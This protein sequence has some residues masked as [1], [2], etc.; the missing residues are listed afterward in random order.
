MKNKFLKLFCLCF[1]GYLSGCTP[2]QKYTWNQFDESVYEYYKSPNER[3]NY[4]EALQQIIKLSED[5]GKIPP[6]IYAEYGYVN[7]ETGNYKEAVKY[8]QKEHDTWPESR[9]FMNKMI[10]NAKNLD[11]NKPNT[12]NQP[13][14]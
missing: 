10:R 3:A 9:F 12:S 11:N 14:S 6:G 1:F 2:I 13:N 7:Y 8:F 4:V 5:S